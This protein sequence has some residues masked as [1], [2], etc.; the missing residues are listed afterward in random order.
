MTCRRESNQKL[1]VYHENKSKLTLQ[2]NDQVS[3]ISIEVDGCEINDSSIRCDFMHIAK[4]I[5]FFIEL[6]G[7]DIEHAVNQIINTINRLSPDI[8]AKEK[9]SYIICTRSPISSTKIQKYK[10]HF[11]KNY[12]S[13]FIVKSSPYKDFY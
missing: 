1:F 3:S 2:N 12:N 6:K 13:D 7:Q 5:E 10:Y 9:R 11:K 4:E 8:R